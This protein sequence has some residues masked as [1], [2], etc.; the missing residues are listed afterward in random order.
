MSASPVALIVNLPPIDINYF[1]IPRELAAILDDIKSCLKAELYY[2]ALAV[3]LTI[4]EI[5]QGLT[6]PLNQNVTSKHYVDFLNEYSTVS[7]LGV[8]G[9]GC[10]QL[11]CGTVHRGNPLASRFSGQTHVIFSTR[12][13]S[14]VHALTLAAEDKSAAMFMLY[15]FCEAMELAVY[16]WFNQNSRD[17]NIQK[18]ARDLLRFNADGLHPFIQGF[19]VVVSGPT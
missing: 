1:M 11:R 12:K 3:T 13:D 15:R 10:Y 19:P 5:C 2:P 17:P 18:N 14:G 8:D 16:R 7:E 4:P 9:A 6:L